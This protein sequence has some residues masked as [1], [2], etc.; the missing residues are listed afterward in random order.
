M[1]HG[2]RA[3]HLF[4][5][6]IYFV[7]VFDLYYYIK[8]INYSIG[9]K[10]KKISQSLH[11]TETGISSDLLGHLAR[12]QTLPLPLQHQKKKEKNFLI[13]GFSLP[14]YSVSQFPVTPLRV[15]LRPRK[16]QINRFL[17]L[18]KKAVHDILFTLFGIDAQMILDNDAKFREKTDL[19]I[20]L[21]V[22]SFA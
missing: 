9:K 4:V 8:D 11:A 17:N 13:R 7:F 21:L 18:E 10:K 20:Q 5:L 15:F 14:R 19:I 6:G 2:C 22:T 16:R 12:M 3:K 1:Q